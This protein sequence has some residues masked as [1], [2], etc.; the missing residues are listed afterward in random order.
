[1]IAIISTIFNF[2]NFVMHMNSAILIIANYEH[3]KTPMNAY[4][5]TF[6]AFLF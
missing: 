4:F 2:Q 3:E 6:K 5:T 1:M